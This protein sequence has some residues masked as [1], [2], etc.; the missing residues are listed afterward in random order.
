M[1][2]HSLFRNG[3]TGMTFRRF[4][5]HCS[6]FRIRYATRERG[7]TEFLFRSAAEKLE[8]VQIKI[9]KSSV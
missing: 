4:D 2:V 7:S 1:I 6:L 9:D 5:N 3:V 8:R